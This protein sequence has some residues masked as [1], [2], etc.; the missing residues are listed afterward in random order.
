MIIDDLGEFTFLSRK[1]L[2][3]EGT[4]DIAKVMAKDVIE[5]RF[6][7]VSNIENEIFQH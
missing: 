4:S 5:T 7:Y 6:K 3:S 2:L 1:Y